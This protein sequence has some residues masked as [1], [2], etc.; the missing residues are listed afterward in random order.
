MQAAG[1]PF[2]NYQGPALPRTIK[3]KEKKKL[4]LAF[5]FSFFFVDPLFF[6]SSLPLFTLSESPL[7]LSPSV[8]HPNRRLL[9]STSPSLFVVEDPKKGVGLVAILLLAFRMLDFFC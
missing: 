9:A 8:L 4:T 7:P 1:G 5:I 2:G 3:R 6:S